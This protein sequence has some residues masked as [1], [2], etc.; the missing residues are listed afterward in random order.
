MNFFYKIKSQSHFPVQTLP[1]DENSLHDLIIYYFNHSHLN[2]DIHQLSLSLF[3]LSFKRFLVWIQK[4]LFH[5]GFLSHFIPPRPILESLQTTG[6]MA[7]NSKQV[8]ELEKSRKSQWREDKMRRKRTFRNNHLISCHT[9]FG[10]AFSCFFFFFVF[11]SGRKEEDPGTNFLFPN[12]F[13]HQG[14]S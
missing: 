4:V 10:S 13:S 7:L 2:I 14:F 11:L 12:V 5:S 3:F 1:L 9:L 6:K 8:K